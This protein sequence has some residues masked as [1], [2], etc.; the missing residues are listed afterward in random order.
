MKPRVAVGHLGL[1]LFFVTWSSP[2]FA[3]ETIEASSV[4]N[5]AP[6]EAFSV[7]D[8]FEAV[9][10]TMGSPYAEQKTNVVALRDLQADLDK[11]LG[12]WLSEKNSQ[13]AKS[14]PPRTLLIEPRI[15]KVKFIGTNARLW[16][17]AFAGSSRVLIKVRFTDKA[18]GALVAE[19]EFY[20]HAAGMAGAWS[21]G[22]ADKAMLERAAS[23]VTDYV[24]ANLDKAVGGPTG[25]E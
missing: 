11:R 14:D 16:A 6:T 24:R 19:P 1:L 7:F 18:T 2:V 12:P 3:G 10:A 15:E 22:A 13:P 20:Q 9:P 23:L 21:F 4:S 25:K 5:P 8:R 17:G